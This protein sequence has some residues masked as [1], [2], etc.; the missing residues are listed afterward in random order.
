MEQFKEKRKKFYNKLHSLVQEVEAGNIYHENAEIFA[1]HPINE[2][3]GLKNINKLWKSLRISF[4]D[5]ERRDSI[6]V[7]GAN[8]PDERSLVNIEGIEL[9]ASMCHYQGTFENDLFGIP[10]SKKVVY[11]RSCEVHQFL[12]EKIIKSYIILDLLNLMKQVGLSPI[13]PSLG[14]DFFWPGPASADGVRIDDNDNSKASNC[15]EVVMKMH[16][17]L[18]E[19]D[20]KEIESMKHSQYWSKNFIWYGPSGIGTSKGM[21]N[22]RNIHQIPF[23]RG[24]SDRKGASHYIRINDGNYVVTG[25]W[26]SVEATHGGE[27]LGIPATNK[28]IKMRVMD[29]YRVEGNVIAEN[30]V[31][32]D[33]IHILYQMGFDVFARLKEM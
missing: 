5:I 4:P 20:G 8:F 13:S 15:F 30:W 11:L 28:K 7:L 18:G 16:K 24:F 12:N 27:W 22:F 26:P 31:P 17:A 21:N 10:A 19:Y 29:F 1:C 6:F 33:I 2:I 23:L 32:I 3:S 14:T 9:V 25:G